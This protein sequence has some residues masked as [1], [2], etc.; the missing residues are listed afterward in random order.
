MRG[1]RG[2]GQ[3]VRTP[4][5][6]SP[7]KYHKN[8]KFLSNTGPDPLK[9]LKLPSQHSTLGHRR[10]LKAFHWRADDGPLLVIFGSSLPYKRRKKRCQKSDPDQI[11]M[12]FRKE[13][14]VDLN[15][16]ACDRKH[17]KHHCRISD[18]VVQKPM[19]TR[20]I[21]KNPFQH[22]YMIFF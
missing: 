19:R 17:A 6:P 8:L 12:E 14:F 1:S 20:S 21:S 11:R 10:R 9:F 18:F 15:I 2:R 4:P 5:P 22:Q 3:K 13:Y 16:W 7:V